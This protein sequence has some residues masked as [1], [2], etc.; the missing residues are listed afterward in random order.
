MLLFSRT[1]LFKHCY[2][3]HFLV[4]KGVV[5]SSLFNPLHDGHIKLLNT[6]CRFDD[7]ISLQRQCL[8]SLSNCTSSIEI[9]HFITTRKW[10][11]GGVTTFQALLNTL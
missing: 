4:V 2:D 8:R 1:L 7:S 3:P 5:L 9:Q 10:R 6:A 11:E